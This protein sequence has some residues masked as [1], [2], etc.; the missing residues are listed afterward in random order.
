MT[1]SVRENFHD[2]SNA[3]GGILVGAELGERR[4]KTDDDRTAF[5]T[6]AT[7]ARRAAD[8]ISALRPA[9]V[10]ASE[11]DQ[12]D[13][14]RDGAYVESLSPKIA[15]LLERTKQTCERDSVPLLD[16]AS[17]RLLALLVGLAKPASILEL[18]TANGY[19]ALWM[20]QAFDEAMIITIDP[21]AG[22]AAT[23]RA[24]FREAGV[25]DRIEIVER[26][27]LDV[28]ADLGDR[29][30]DLVFIDAVK[31]EYTAYLDALM[32]SVRMGGLVIADNLLWSHRASSIPSNDDDPTTV[33]I[34]TFNAR[35]LSHP[36]LHAVILPVGD[37]IGVGVKTG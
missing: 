33:G 18:G 7:G 14:A 19:S 35:F 27:A 34:R 23:A 37:G 36:S 21:D 22:R 6:L 3:V 8:L 32:P 4:S 5:A 31:T 24:L 12:S 17:A 9:I 11:S 10:T 13:V 16:L 30:F 29:R 26:P 1:R 20:A 25:A 15:P 2:L 28:I